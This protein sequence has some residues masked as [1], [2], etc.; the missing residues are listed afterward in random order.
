MSPQRITFESGPKRSGHPEA[1]APIQSSSPSESS[2]APQ[3]LCLQAQDDGGHSR[4]YRSQM[5][6]VPFEDSDVLSDA[7]QQVT[8]LTNKLATMEKE[9][10]ESDTACVTKI[11]EE[12]LKMADGDEY[13]NNIYT[14]NG[15][16]CELT[17]HLF[18]GG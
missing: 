9:R 11:H 16:Q 1:E 15:P 10:K 5:W 13:Q 6:T 14:V 12:S 7:L 2:G 4:L 3:D 17:I 18:D 8:A